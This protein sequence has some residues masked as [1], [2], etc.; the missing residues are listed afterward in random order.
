MINQTYFSNGNDSS[1]IHQ[2]DDPI[3]KPFLPNRYKK[4]F[5]L[6]TVGV[7]NFQPDD[8]LEYQLGK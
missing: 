5:K 3:F 8:E 2:L 7:G 1:K 4:R 6:K